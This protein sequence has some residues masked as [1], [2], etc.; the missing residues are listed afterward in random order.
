MY[1]KSTENERRAAVTASLIAFNLNSVPS[2]ASLA[3]G[4]LPENSNS[5]GMRQAACYETGRHDVIHG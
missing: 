1:V 2:G 5:F 4:K 3:I